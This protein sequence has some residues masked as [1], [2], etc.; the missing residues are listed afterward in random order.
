MPTLQ[1]KRLHPNAVLPAYAKFGD[2]GL[3][4]YACENAPVAERK[5]TKVSTGIAMDIPHG[6]VGLIW[7]RSGL[8]LNSGIIVL[9]GVV[10]SGYRGEIQ[11][12]LSSLNG[13][14]QVV[15]GEK[16][17]QMLIQPVET[18]TTL[19]VQEVSELSMSERGTAGFGSTK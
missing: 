11:V 19:Q 7:P 15:A 16:I 1:I 13:S 9:A 8:A 14:Y 12:L 17:A 6:Y 3:D 10:D 2:A 4:L 5:V 18:G